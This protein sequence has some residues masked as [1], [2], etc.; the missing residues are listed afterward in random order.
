MGGVRG[1]EA[2]SG[3]AGAGRLLA[4]EA[5]SVILLRALVKVS[6]GRRLS[7]FVPR[8]AV[9]VGGRDGPLA[10]LRASPSGSSRAGSLGLGPKEACPD[11][12]PT[13][14]STAHL[15][16]PV[17]AV[18]LPSLPQTVLHVAGMQSVFF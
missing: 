14:L 10:D 3:E 15:A 17:A 5:G 1:S 13:A 12:P 6:P 7:R 18:G 8:D 11:R 4:D 9:G 2:G 16:E